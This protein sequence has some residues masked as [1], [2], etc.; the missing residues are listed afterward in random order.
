MVVQMKVK[1]GI[2]PGETALKYVQNLI[3]Q[4]RQVRGGGI[5]LTLKD[6]YILEGPGSVDFSGNESSAGKLKKHPKLKREGD[7]YGWWA[8]GGGNYVIEFNEKISLPENSYALLS[9]RPQLVINEAFHPTMLLHP[10]ENL[11]RITLS[12]GSPGINLKENAKI[13]RLSIFEF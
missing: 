10:G 8:L 2:V 3:D 7:A 1:G 6:V 13:S 11:G 9:P 12:V 5:E 4:A